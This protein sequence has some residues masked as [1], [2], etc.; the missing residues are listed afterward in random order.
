MCRTVRGA[1]WCR[2]QSAEVGKEA[3]HRQDDGSLS[4]KRS[5]FSFRERIHA[6]VRGKQK[7]TPGTVRR[8]T[9]AR[10]GLAWPA[11]CKQ[12]CVSRKKGPRNSAA[13]GKME[14]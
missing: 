5:Q 13:K 7:G 11:C 8:S 14:G 2:I 3:F 1:G 10:H 4:V 12:F 6:P 9:E